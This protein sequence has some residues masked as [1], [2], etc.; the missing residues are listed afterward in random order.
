MY[1]TKILLIFQNWNRDAR[2]ILC[3]RAWLSEQLLFSKLFPKMPPLTCTGTQSL[4]LVAIYIN[5]TN[6]VSLYRP[7]EAI[8]E[9][10]YWTNVFQRVKLYRIRLVLHLDSNFEKWAILVLYI[11]YGRTFKMTSP[12]QMHQLRH[13]R[14]AIQGTL[15]DHL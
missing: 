12:G 14:L 15:L 7:K 8:W 6:S 2:L 4:T 10:V 9:I 5:I 1:V 11:S 3:D 13:L